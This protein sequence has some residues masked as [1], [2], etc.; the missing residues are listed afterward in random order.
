MIPLSETPIY[1]EMLA[2]QER[3]EMRESYYGTA[4]VE[5]MPD[6]SKFREQSIQHMM[7]PFE[8]NAG[9]DFER[10]LLNLLTL[11][12]A[13]VKAFPQ[14]PVEVH[15]LSRNTG[16]S[17]EESAD[18]YQRV[19]KWSADAITKADLEALNRSRMSKPN[20]YPTSTPAWSRK[21]P[22]K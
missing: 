1:A 9:T 17:L 4:W 10:A 5:I 7:R 13:P 21:K 16:W 18:V 8:A 2:E 3:R 14:Y 12:S 11:G 19:A 6:I 20:H 22:R 15:E